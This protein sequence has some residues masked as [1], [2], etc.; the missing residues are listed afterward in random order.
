[1]T[2]FNVC[3]KITKSIAIEAETKEEAVRILEEDY[4]ISMDGDLVDHS[5]EIIE[6]EELNLPHDVG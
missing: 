6:V 2:T 5:L 4:S 3:W 1:M